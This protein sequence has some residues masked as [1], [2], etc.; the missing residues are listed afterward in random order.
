LTRFAPAGWL[1]EAPA[2]SATL[3]LTGLAQSAASAGRNPA[4]QVA[5]AGCLHN[6]Q[7]IDA[8]VGD[9]GEDDAE[10]IAR[11]LERGPG[12]FECV[13][14]VFAFA[15]RDRASGRGALGRDPLG[16]VPMFYAATGTGWLASPSLESIAAA[17]KPD[18]DRLLLAEMLSDSW[19]GASDTPLLGVKRVPPATLITIDGASISFARYWDPSLK[20]G[21]HTQDAHAIQEKFA[22]L[23]EQAVVRLARL[24]RTGIFLSGGVDS[25]S[26]AAAA[27]KATL[28]QGLPLPVALAL[29]FRGSAIDEEPVQ[30]FVAQSLRFP[31]VGLA[32]DEA[33]K[34]GAAID[35]LLGMSQEW[36]MPVANIWM[37]AYV[38]LAAAG[39]AAGCEVILTGGGGDEWLG[40]SPYL[41]AD[42]MRRL[43]FGKLAKL[44]GNIRRSTEIPSHLIARQYLW[45]FGVK[46]LI[47]GA[48]N[49]VL[50]PLGFPLDRRRARKSFP[51]WLVLNG[52]FGS[53]LLARAEDAR[54]SERLARARSAS[55]YEYEMKRSL[56]HPVVLSELESRF[57]M[58]ERAGVRVLEPYWD[59]DLVELLYHT[60]PEVLHR[61]NMQKGL[62]RQLLREAIPEMKIPR[63]NKI[64]GAKY[65]QERV[66]M[67][68][69]RAWHQFGG[70][71]RLDE[72]GIV[73]NGKLSRLLE[74]QFA[75][76]AASLWLVP[77]VLSIEAWVRARS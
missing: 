53:D 1:A 58:G 28:E 54:R 41:T 33:L 16:T 70:A 49:L 59:A 31:L 50:P 72:M 10:R 7:E 5:F 20:T 77:H 73:D 51:D 75:D 26:V 14:G 44:I 46:Q 45:T 30:T 25:I 57:E 38:R 2:D 18:L 24:G 23:L 12:H 56:A 60:P 42:F 40:V 21:G 47:V 36:S 9:C 37:P 29:F 27:S 68:A 64:H 76:P 55:L 32:L 66:R 69:R 65:F 35:E 39:R 61:G 17:S 6:R 74:T 8:R 19:S 48:R 34:S 71:R 13:R 67:E 52:A 62:V 43:R 63:N 11:L 3:R 4:W 15:A 22:S